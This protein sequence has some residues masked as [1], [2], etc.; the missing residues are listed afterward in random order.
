MHQEQEQ[1]QE[2]GHH[3]SPP[4]GEGEPGRSTARTRPSGR[5]KEAKHKRNTEGLAEIGT[6]GL[7]SG[8]KET[9]KTGTLVYISRRPVGK[10]FTSTDAT[11][12][13]N[14][15]QQQWA[16]AATHP[17]THPSYSRPVGN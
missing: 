12:V 14:R 3:S 7:F 5:T 4:T 16:G 15:K 6:G 9:E 1:E 2:H 13:V 11:T 10:N 8:N 17:S